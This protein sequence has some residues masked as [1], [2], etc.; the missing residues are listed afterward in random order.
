M[1]ALETSKNIRQHRSLNENNKINEFLFLSIIISKS[2]LFSQELH[3]NSFNLISFI[4]PKNFNIKVNKKKILYIQQQAKS[5]HII[6]LLS[7]ISNKNI[8]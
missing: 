6:S 4:N 5:I 7:H 1:K 8:S 3:Y 2:Q